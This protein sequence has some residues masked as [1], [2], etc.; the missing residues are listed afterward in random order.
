MFKV[1]GAE[2]TFST[3][4]AGILKKD[5]INIL[6][7]AKSEK[8]VAKKAKKAEDKGSPEWIAFIEEHFESAEMY[9]AGMTKERAKKILDAIDDNR[10]GKKFIPGG[11][12]VILTKKTKP[13]FWVEID[14]KFL[15]K[16]IQGEKQSEYIELDANA[17]VYGLYQIWKSDTKRGYGLTSTR[18]QKIGTWEKKMRQSGARVEDVAELEKILKR[19]I[20]LLDITHGT[21]FNSRKYRTGRFEEIEMVIHNGHAFP[22]NH[23]F[24]RD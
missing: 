15:V 11:P 19:P 14:E 5:F 24:P 17:V 2:Y 3:W 10:A 21:I 22:R 4:F 1:D 12:N 9:E 20:K 7:T 6:L 13:S 16:I 18:K 23:H 8:E